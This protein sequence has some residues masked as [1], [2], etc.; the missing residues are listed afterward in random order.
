MSRTNETDERFIKRALELAASG[1][2]LVSPN[3][4]VG[5]VIVS[6]TGEVVGEGAYEYAGVTHAEVI[7]LEQA[8]SKAKGGTAYVSLEPHD[9]HGKTPPCTEALINA[10]INRVV[11]PIEDPNPKVSGRGFQHLKNEGIEVVTGI[12]AAEAAKLNEKFICW[13]QKGRPFVH[14]KLATSFDGR[15]SLR[16]SVSTAISNGTALR[17]VH[18]I[19]NEYDAILIGATTAVV[20]DPSLTDRSGRPRRRPLVRVVLD[21]RLRLRTDSVLATTTAAAPTLVFTN[22]IDPE[23]VKAIAETGV[24]VVPVELGARNLRAVLAELASREIQSI[25]VEGGTEVA[26]AFIDAKL[27]DKVTFIAAPIIIGGKDAPVAIGGSGAKTLGDAVQLND[28]SIT[29][30]DGNFEVTGYPVHKN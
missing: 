22:C 5:C 21:N 27:V 28:V 4:L 7:A 18:E 3:P 26:G 30:L 24:E 14:L 15:I 20:D 19:R 12:L 16:N 10:G 23:R 1:V 29:P 11:A 25:L 9:H 2:A 17:R 6:E 8:G 13:H